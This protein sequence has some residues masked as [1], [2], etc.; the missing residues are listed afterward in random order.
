MT[1]AAVLCIRDFHYVAFIKAG[2]D[3]MS[4]WIFY[5]PGANNAVAKVLCLL[6]IHNKVPK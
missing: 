5:D 6:F 3:V 1:L 2:Q 4:P